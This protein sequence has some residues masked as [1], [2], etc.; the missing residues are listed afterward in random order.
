MI[1]VDIFHAG[2]KRSS[3]N[4]LRKFL[5]FTESFKYRLSI[6]QFSVALVLSMNTDVNFFMYSAMPHFS[7]C[8]SL[9]VDSVE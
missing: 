3:A 8:T 5:S 4:M 7:K 2:F 9:S 1:F 6:F